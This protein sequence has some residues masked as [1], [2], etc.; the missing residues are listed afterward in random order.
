MASKQET[1][2]VEI[3]VRSD[4]ASYRFSVD[5]NEESFEFLI[6]W[7]TRDEAWFITIS[8]TDG[9]VILAGIKVVVN[10]LLTRLFRL[11]GL[12]RGDLIA[13]DISGTNEPCA[14]HDFGVRVKLMFIED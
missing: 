7:N 4:L 9:I 11:S 14:R 8:D 13:V 3:P 10:W 6:E 12:P 5:L 2:I 1:M